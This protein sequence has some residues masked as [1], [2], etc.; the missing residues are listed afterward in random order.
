MVIAPDYSCRPP[1]RTQ[2]FRPLAGAVYSLTDICIAA[3]APASE[4]DRADPLVGLP[5]P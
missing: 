3:N 5:I 2:K 1:K 4:P